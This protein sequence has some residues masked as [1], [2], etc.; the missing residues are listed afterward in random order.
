MK[1][2][3]F[4]LARKHLADLPALPVRDGVD[5]I[6]FTSRIPRALACQVVRLGLTE[7]GPVRSGTRWAAPICQGKAIF[8]GQVDPRTFRAAHLELGW[9]V[10]P[11]GIYHDPTG[12]AALR[13]KDGEV[14]MLVKQEALN[15]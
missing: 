10:S 9:D 5:Q 14:I 12:M 2:T 3:D 6:V 15:G 8:Y 11:L 13:Y 4:A 1:P 7:A